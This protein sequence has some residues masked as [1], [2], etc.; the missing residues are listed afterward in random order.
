M[1]TDVDSAWWFQVTGEITYN[2]HTFKEFVPQRTSAYVNQYD[3]VIAASM[4]RE[5]RQHVD[6]PGLT[7]MALYMWKLA[8]SASYHY[9]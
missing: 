6:Q 7:L 4:N 9:G 3:E 2:G 1:R 8:Q 5:G